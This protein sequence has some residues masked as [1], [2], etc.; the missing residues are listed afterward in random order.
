MN[1]N[2]KQYFSELSRQ[3]YSMLQD[4]INKRN[5]L[6]GIWG[7]TAT[8]CFS[9]VFFKDPQQY[10][11]IK[12]VVLVALFLLGILLHYTTVGMFAWQNTYKK[13]CIVVGNILLNIEKFENLK[14][15]NNFIEKEFKKNET[16]SKKSVTYIA[17]F[18]C[19]FPTL[20]PLW[21]LWGINDFLPL[22]SMIVCSLSYII[23]STAIL[24]KRID[25]NYGV[26]WLLKFKTL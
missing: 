21:V 17:V 18:C 20:I 15:I 19:F 25:K 11:I 16:K 23:I 9:I 13:S 8:I 14:S 22:I 26:P 3:C 7:T 2:Q 12:N 5:T 6:M 1:E 4:Q 24:N 10:I